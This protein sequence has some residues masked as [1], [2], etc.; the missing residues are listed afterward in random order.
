MWGFEMGVGDMREFL[1][2]RSAT[3]ELGALEWEISGLMLNP[4]FLLI[5]RL[6]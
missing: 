3:S 5:S 2:L 4:L 6:T 1:Y